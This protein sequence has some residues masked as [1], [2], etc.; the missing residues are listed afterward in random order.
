MSLLMKGGVY[1]YPPTYMD[2]LRQRERIPKIVKDEAGAEKVILLKE[3]EEKGA[4]AAKGRPV[5]P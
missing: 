4:A 3:E 1:S 5:G 2:L